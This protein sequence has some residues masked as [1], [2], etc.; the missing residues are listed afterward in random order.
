MNQG[1]VVR[2]VCV[3]G[4]VAC[5]AAASMRAWQVMEPAIR[6]KRVAATIEGV[7]LS[8]THDGDG[9]LVY[10]VEAKVRFPVAGAEVS[11]VAKSGL[12]SRAYAESR[13]EV[14]EMLNLRNTQVYFDP[15]DPNR[16]LFNLHY[17]RL[18]D[19]RMGS[20]LMG[21]LALLSFGTWFARYWAGRSTCARC[22][23]PL[24][25]HFTY[26][27]HCRTLLKPASA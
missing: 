22:K 12:Q 7:R 5:I 2:L 17:S 16:A 27:P 11:T 18:Y 13:A 26:C 3:V 10:F 4:S 1:R 20:L 14:R 25:S 24:R 15:A 9:R 8:Y 21:A 19:W 6:F 23:M